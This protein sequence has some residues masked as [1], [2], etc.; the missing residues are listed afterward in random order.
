M[1]N[2]T[3]QNILLWVLYF[4]LGMYA[5]LELVQSLLRKKKPCKDTVHNYWF[6]FT[7]QFNEFLF[8]SV[9]AYTLF[10]QKV[11]PYK[12]FNLEGHGVI[13]YALMFALADL[14][15]YA[16][17]WSGHH[18]PILWSTIHVMHHSSKQYNLSTGYRRV[19]YANILALPLFLVL[20]F[21]GI[22]LT[23]LNLMLLVVFV[24]QTVFVHF[25]SVPSLGFLE[26]IINTPA[27][28]RVHHS[29]APENFGK[30]LGPFLTIWDHLFGTFKLEVEKTTQFGCAN[31][32][33]NEGLLD[34]YFAE[35]KRLYK[36][37]M[38]EEHFLG[39]LKILF[40]F[41]KAP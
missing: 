5:L 9:G 36:R 8:L 7:T 38:Q 32:E 1:N 24:Y 3:V 41:S 2:M 17:H 23:D 14:I 19:N 40:I 12:L 39:K 21:L 29:S 37:F 13:Y 6:V 4:P 35:M 31:C 22:N 27:K 20:G 30:N 25:E 26:Y 34:V 16:V 28:H 18:L 15:T 10:V 11:L 33:K